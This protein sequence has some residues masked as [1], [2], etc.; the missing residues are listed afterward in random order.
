[1]I[2]RKDWHQPFIDRL[3]EGTLS[4]DTT[5]ARQLSC[6]AKSFVLIDG[7]LYKRSTSGI[8]QKCVTLEEG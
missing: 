2:D 4:E 8:K 1:M 3:S 6:K 5:E 7:T